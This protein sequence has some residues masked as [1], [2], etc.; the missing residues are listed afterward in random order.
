MSNCH[1][2]NGIAWNA[3]TFS[4]DANELQG[5]TGKDRN[6]AC[7]IINEVRQRRI[8]SKVWLPWG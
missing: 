3:E 4:S 1:A 7:R 8:W 2:R 5:D 6:A